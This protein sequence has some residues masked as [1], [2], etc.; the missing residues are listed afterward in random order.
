MPHRERLRLR[1]DQPR[2]REGEAHRM[3]GHAERGI[4][5]IRESR[6]HRAVRE[7]QHDC[8]VCAAWDAAQLH[9]AA[10]AVETRQRDVRLGGEHVAGTATVDALEC[11]GDETSRDVGVESRGAVE[12]QARLEARRIVIGRTVTATR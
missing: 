1:V 2:L 11:H 9:E 8:A 5:T 12:E 4:A 3:R 10:A 7:A 6:A